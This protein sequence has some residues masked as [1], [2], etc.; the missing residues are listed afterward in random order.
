MKT[1][2]REYEDYLKD[3]LY[4]AEKAQSFVHGMDFDA[5]SL[6]TRAAETWPQWNCL[7]HRSP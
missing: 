5:F 6:R 4:A 3:M 2:R 1:S 7:M